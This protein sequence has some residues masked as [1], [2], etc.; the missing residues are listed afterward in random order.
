MAELLTPD[1]C[2]IGGGITSAMLAQKITALRPALRV[3]VVEAGRSIADV[4]NRGRYRERGV[5][6]RDRY[7]W[8]DAAFLRT[9]RHGRRT[10]IAFL[11]MA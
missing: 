8:N 3:T 9:L 4:A 2:V 10:M 5:I 1:I 7:G 11:L 6:L